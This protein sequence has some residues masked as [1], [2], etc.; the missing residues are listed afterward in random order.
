MECHAGSH[1]IFR[2]C[3]LAHMR[4]FASGAALLLWAAAAMAQAPEPGARVSL[5]LRDGT[6]LSGRLVEENGPLLLLETPYGR[7][8][9][10]RDAVV[11]LEVVEP[12]PKA[13]SAPPNPTAASAPPKP[14]TP[15]K[16]P[17]ATR[18]RPEQRSIV[19]PEQV[20]QAAGRMPT[21]QL[22]LAAPPEFA[23]SLLPDLVERFARLYGVQAVM[24]EHTEDGQR[25]LF[26]E[27]PVG[28]PEEVMVRA[29]SREGALTRLKSGEVDL[30]LARET[31]EEEEERAGLEEYV[32]ALDAVVPL[33][34]PDNPLPRLS[35]RTLADLLAGRIDDWAV[36]G[37]KPGPVRRVV[38]GP[39]LAISRFLRA[40]LPGLERMAPGTVYVRDP[41]DL[42]DELFSDPGSV[43]YGSRL[44]TG[45]A[46]VPAII[47]C[48]IVHP[49]ESF[50]V[51]AE[52]WPLTQRIK[53][54]LWADAVDG[55]E[56]VFA[57]F[58]LSAQGERAMADFQLEPLTIRPATV[59][60]QDAWVNAVLA[61]PQ[62]VPEVRRAFLELARSARRLTVVFRFETGSAELDR[63]AREDVAR[64]ALWLEGEGIDPARLV[65]VGHADSRGGYQSNLVLARARAQSVAAALAQ[66]G[67]Q[68]GNVMA[69]GE[70]IPLACDTDPQGL[71]LNRRVEAWLRSGG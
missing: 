26:K 13:A 53:A 71:R 50:R 43:G 5:D 12:P 59:A 70:E 21:P 37:S 67:I 35:R 4:V 8:L 42:L 40:R 20:E 49:P 62:Q 65:L 3:T 25:A 46:H 18:P 38:P 39:E 15:R 52:D 27:N 6:R 41:D 10:P 56:D 58:L 60:E 69:F 47:E 7:L 66:V 2:R 16:V 45:G 68:V 57:L 32:V 33:L 61:T 24:W 14:S 11:G 64:L 63:R 31:D 23:F 36:L 30:V 51:R 44:A 22:V 9:I 29:L 34:H 17:T 28:F 54:Y 1:A 55:W 19:S 48:G